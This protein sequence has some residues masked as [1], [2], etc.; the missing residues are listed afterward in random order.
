MSNPS[1]DALGALRRL[2]YII[3]NATQMVFKKMPATEKRDFYQ[4]D[5]LS[6]LSACY[7]IC[8]QE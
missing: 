1:G 6:L 5:D 7:R 8:S 3:Q 4:T 2:A